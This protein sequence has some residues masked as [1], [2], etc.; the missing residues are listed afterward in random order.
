MTSS[1]TTFFHSLNQGALAAPKLVSHSKMIDFLRDHLFIFLICLG[2]CIVNYPSFYLHKNLIQRNIIGF[3]TGIMDFL[4]KGKGM[5]PK[6][7]SFR[8]G[9]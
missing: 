7:F 2:Q 9:I 6:A 3:I 5:S 1:I 4:I 8:S